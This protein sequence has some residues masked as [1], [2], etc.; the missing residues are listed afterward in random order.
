MKKEKQGHDC[1]VSFL[2]SI[3]ENVSFTI[4]RNAYKVDFSS[5]NLPEYLDSFEYKK[6]FDLEELEKCLD[7]DEIWEIT[8]YTESEVALFWAAGSTLERALED[9]KRKIKERLSEN[10]YQ[11]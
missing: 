3:P 1:F 4:E 7:K 6:E 11:S 8:L 2:K 10:K 9:L 5:T